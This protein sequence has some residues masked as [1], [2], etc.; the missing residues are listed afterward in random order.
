MPKTIQRR[1]SKPKLTKKT[2]K[3]RNWILIFAL[4]CF[5]LYV[6][7]TIVDQQIKINNARTE[8]S[9]LNNTISIQKIK[10]TELKKVA[11]AVDNDDLSSFSDYIE[12]VARED[13]DYVKNGEVVFVNIAGD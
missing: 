13:L 10:N 2:K 3:R 12:R 4:I 8:L 7:V 9:E 6:A 1:L 11:D 5:S